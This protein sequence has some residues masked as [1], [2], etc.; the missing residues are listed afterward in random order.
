MCD[1]AEAPACGGQLKSTGT[2]ASVFLGSRRS[3]VPAPRLRGR[4][5]LLFGGADHRVFLGC[6]NCSHSIVAR[7]AI[8][9]ATTA[10]ISAAT[11]S[12]INSMISEVSFPA[13]AHGINSRAR[14]LS[15]SIRVRIPGRPLSDMVNRTRAKDAAQCLVL[16]ILNTR[17]KPAEAPPNDEVGVH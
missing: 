4:R 7:C 13:T 15:L 3:I 8:N 14:A 2:V 17:E 5:L 10:Q 9:S 1:T 12:G 11:A 6:L 16:G